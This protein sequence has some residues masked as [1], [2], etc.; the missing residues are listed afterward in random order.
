MRVAIAVV[1]A[2][3]VVRAE[4]AVLPECADHRDHGRTEA[5]ETCYEAALRRE[6]DPRVLAEAQWRLGRRQE[7]N[8]LF[9]RAVAERPKDPEPR[10]AWGRL[11]LDSHNGAEAAKLFEEALGL[12]EKSAGARLGLAL[13]AADNFDERAKQ[14][15]QW[16]LD[17]DPRLAEAH[18]LMARLDLEEERTREAEAHLHEAEALPGSPL[19]ALALRAAQAWSRART[20]ARG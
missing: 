6:R 9:R 8:A 7:A 2:L 14:H 20:P 5:A 3:N 1:L 11:F 13:V 17:I 19:P 10:I 15:A 4:A 16:A 18:L 12:Q